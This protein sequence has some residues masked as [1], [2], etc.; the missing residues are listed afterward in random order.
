MIFLVAWAVKKKVSGMPIVYGKREITYYTLND[1]K[2][3][4]PRK[5]MVERIKFFISSGAEGYVR[6][7]Y[8][9]GL[10]VFLVGVVTYDDLNLWEFL[11][12]NAV[13]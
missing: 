4:Q 3:F 11:H 13:H 2:L 6:G 10:S 8:V 5:G 7:G 1:V 12:G 9:R